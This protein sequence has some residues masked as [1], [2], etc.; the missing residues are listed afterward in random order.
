ME[1][2]WMDYSAADTGYQIILYCSLHCSA[3]SFPAGSFELAVTFVHYYCYTVWLQIF[4]VENFRNFC[5]YAV[6][7]KILFT[8]FSSQLIIRLNCYGIMNLLLRKFTFTENQPFYE[9]FILRKFGAIRYNGCW[10]ESSNAV[11]SLVSWL[12]GVV[13]I[14][15]SSRSSS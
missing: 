8:K 15:S 9:I 7:T 1:G 5:N 10:C 4:V 11:C 2:H 14:P 3:F 12:G 13:D 6:I